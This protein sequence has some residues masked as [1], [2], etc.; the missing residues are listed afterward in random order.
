MSKRY[1][2]LKLPE[3]FFDATDDGT[4]E[5]IEELEGGREYVLFYL[6]L[7][8][9]ALRT[10]GTL[11]RYIGM[12]CIP[13]D[14]TSLAKLTNTPVEIVHRAV[15]VLTEVGLLRRLDSGE[16]FLT[17]MQ[18]FAGSETDKAAIMR[19]SRARAKLSEGN[20]VTT[21]LPECYPTV[22]Q[23]KSKRIEK[24]IRDREVP[25]GTSCPEPSRKA[26]RQQSEEPFADVEAIPLND[27]SEWRPTVSQYEEYCRLYPNV[28]ISQA[29]RNM[30]GWCNDNPTRRKTPAGIRRFVGSWLSKEQ[31]RG[32]RPSRIRDTRYMTTEEYMQ[33]TAGWSKG[34]DDM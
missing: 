16:L 32:G 18:E 17:Q 22:T 29:F 19:R 25:E 3:N 1:Y 28:D 7:L 13:Y 4:I 20:N 31:N 12:R 26:H 33:A 10:E 15:E 2:W 24:D 27:G 8:C 5:Y 11:I 21:P 34:L 23:S 9:R 14:D 30:R 6:K